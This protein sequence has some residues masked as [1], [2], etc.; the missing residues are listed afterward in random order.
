[1]P[2]TGLNEYSGT[3]TLFSIKL[4]PAV[5]STKPGAALMIDLIDGTILL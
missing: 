1:M 4:C 2:R 5:P 3:A